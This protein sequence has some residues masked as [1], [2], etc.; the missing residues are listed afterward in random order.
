MTGWRIDI[1]SATAAQAEAERIVQEA[2]EQAALQQEAEVAIQELEA[3]AVAP[4]VSAEEQAVTEE[5]AKPAAE[6]TDAVDMYEKAA[7]A[8]PIQVQPVDHVAPEYVAETVEAKEAGDMETSEPVLATS[9][10]ATV[11]DRP[12]LRFAEDI[13]TPAPAKVGIKEKKGKGKR[14]AEDEAAGHKFPKAKKGGGSR[15]PFIEEELD[16]YEGI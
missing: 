5:E 4:V 11:A 16:E 1:R 3:A 14:Q 7:E 9:A 8:S 6:V 12:R 2:A 13:F 15:R 10:A